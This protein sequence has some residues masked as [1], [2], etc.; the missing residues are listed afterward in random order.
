[1]FI[2]AYHGSPHDFEKFS[3]EKIGTGEGAQA[4]GHGLYFAEK[5]AVAKDYKKTLGNKQWF[6]NDQLVGEYG[7]NSQPLGRAASYLEQAMGGDG[8]A[9]PEQVNKAIADFTEVHRRNKGMIPTK[10][11]AETID[12][13][14]G[15]VGQKISTGGTR[16]RRS[17]SRLIRR[18][19]S[20]G[21]AVERQWKRFARFSS[22]LHGQRK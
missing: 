9:T 6:V 17:T 3:M 13:M 16:T 15:L 14:K 10:E 12:A 22:F 1:V 7:S 20:T 2:R 18:I 19:F 5:E 8:I 21:A 4:Y 11:Q